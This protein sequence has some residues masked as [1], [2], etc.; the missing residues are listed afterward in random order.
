M[1]HNTLEVV[2]DIYP[3]HLVNIDN[4][5]IAFNLGKNC[6]NYFEDG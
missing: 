3:Y 6:K 1:T 4:W 5:D 2:A